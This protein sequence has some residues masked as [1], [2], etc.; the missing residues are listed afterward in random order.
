MVARERGLKL[1]E[2]ASSYCLR[3]LLLPPLRARCRLFSF[4]G[5]SERIP[6]V[7]CLLLERLCSSISIV[8]FFEAPKA[9]ECPAE[10]APPE[11]EA[12]PCDEEI[13]LKGLATAFF[14][15]GRVAFED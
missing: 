1:S 7:P 12:L 3:L 15:L 14:E 2:A 5:V 9:R 6:L 8:W 11:P 4:P 10:A 13:G